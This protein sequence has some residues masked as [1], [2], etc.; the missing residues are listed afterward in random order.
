MI[1]QLVII[2]DLKKNVCSHRVTER[3]NRVRH[4]TF[5]HLTHL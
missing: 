3:V 5:D 2:K 1:F 4:K